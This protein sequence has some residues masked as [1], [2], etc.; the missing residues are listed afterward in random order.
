[1]H[2]RAYKLVEQRL[3]FLIVYHRRD[4][5]GW[6]KSASVLNHV[7]F[8]NG[9]QPF[10]RPFYIDQIAGSPQLDVLI[11]ASEA[12]LFRQHVTTVGELIGLQRTLKLLEEA[13]ASL[14]PD[15]QY[16]VQ[17]RTV[18]PRRSAPPYRGPG[19]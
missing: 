18:A 8:Q 15:V 1:L 13:D 14:I 4:R 11:P 10:T 16:A 19:Q 2:Y 6:G 5:L 9:Y 17:T 12:T 7:L 3:W